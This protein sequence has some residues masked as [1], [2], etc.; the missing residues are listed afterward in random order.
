MKRSL[1][2]IT[3]VGLAV[4]MLFS[5][6]VIEGKEYG[7][8]AKDCQQ[9][10][11]PPA[12]QQEEQVQSPEFEALQQLIDEGAARS[13]IPL[14]FKVNYFYTKE[15]LTY[16]PLIFEVQ[17]SDISFGKETG[18]NEAQLKAFGTV[19]SPEGEVVAPYFYLP[20][21]L[22]LTDPQLESFQQG[23]YL[24]SVSLFI[25]PGEYYLYFGLRNE[26]DGKMTTIMKPLMVPNFSPDKLSVSDIVL[27][28]ELRRKPDSVLEA[29]TVYDGLSFGSIAYQINFDN[30]FQA[31]DQIE[32]VFMVFGAGV[33]PQTQKPSLKVD[34]I[35][36]KDGTN[37]GQFLLQYQITT[38]SQPLPLKLFKLS[39]G[40]YT[41]EITIADLTTQATITKSVSFVII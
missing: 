13:E 29:I 7:E 19:R 39:P 17:G 8:G 37:I 14:K 11:P 5:P 32:F 15:N 18:G 20:M 31:E 28:K 16:G 22:Y 36:K 4:L 21:Q 38:V 34:Y 23:D 33:D 35:I 6:E 9:L 30:K 10:S 2:F 12:A 25:P 40:S 24:W 41:F 3:G 26:V 1:M 27:A